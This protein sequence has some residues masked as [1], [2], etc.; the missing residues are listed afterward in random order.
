LVWFGV[1][2]QNKLPGKVAV[3]EHAHSPLTKLKEFEDL[4]RAGL[5]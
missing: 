3:K 5:A 4:L 1:G 2:T